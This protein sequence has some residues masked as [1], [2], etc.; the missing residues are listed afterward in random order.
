MK[1][2][3]KV[4]GILKRISKDFDLKF[5]EKDIGILILEKKDVILLNYILSPM[6]TSFG[7]TPEERIKNIERFL[8][9]EE[10]KKLMRKKYHGGVGKNLFRNKKLRKIAEKYIPELLRKIPDTKFIAYSIPLEEV[11]LHE[12]IHCLLMVNKIFL[13]KPELN[14]ALTNGIMRRYLKW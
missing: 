6:F 10:F 3:N 9:S 1:L 4:L 2:K 11:A 13:P 7:K 12:S 8:S 14:E 5:D